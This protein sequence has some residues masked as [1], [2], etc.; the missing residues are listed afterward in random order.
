MEP[1]FEHVRAAVDAMIAEGR[2]PLEV[3]KFVERFCSDNPQVGEDRRFAIDLPAR[4]ILSTVE[5]QLR[6]QSFDV[7]KGVDGARGLLRAILTK[8][9]AAKPRWLDSVQ[10]LRQEWPFRIS[11]GVRVTRRGEMRLTMVPFLPS[12]IEQFRNELRGLLADIPPGDVARERLAAAA[13]AQGLAADRILAPGDA[14]EGPYSG[15]LRDYS[16]CAKV[17]QVADLEGRHDGVIPLGRWAFADPVRGTRHGPPLYLSPIRRN[18]RTVLREHQGALLCAPQ[19]AGKTDLLVRWAQA[20][21][22][23]GYNLLIVDVKGN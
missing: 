20:A 4:L 8:D 19:N 21:N 16:A 15:T 3:E 7:G 6:S 9:F 14:L 23:A 2:S 22:R 18:G 12:W 10:S 11:V 13:L 17:D 5:F 1:V